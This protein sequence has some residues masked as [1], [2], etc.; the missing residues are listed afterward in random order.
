MKKVLSIVTVAALSAMFVA[1][2]P[3]KE[4]IE[5]RE[6]AKQDSIAAVEKAKQDSIAAVE[7]ENARLAEEAAAAEKAKADS[8]RVADSMANLKGGKKK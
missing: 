5:A 3:S 6:K 8:T 1:C 4:E 2:G 7:A